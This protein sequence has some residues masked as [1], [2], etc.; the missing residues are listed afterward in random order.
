[1]HLSY[2]NNNLKTKIDKLKGKS[3]EFATNSQAYIFLL[4]LIVNIIQ[5]EIARRGLAY[6]PTIRIYL[7]IQFFSI[8]FFSYVYIIYTRRVYLWFFSRTCVCT[9]VHPVQPAPGFPNNNVAVKNNEK[10]DAGTT[11]PYYL[12]IILYMNVRTLYRVRK[13]TGEGSHSFSLCWGI[14]ICIWFVFVFK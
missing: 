13:N 7:P 6:L 1:M 14:L 5:I 4:Y 3:N 2:K 10:E 12:Y 8:I 11:S 9:C